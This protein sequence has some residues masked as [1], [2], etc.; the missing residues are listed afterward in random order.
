[1]IWLIHADLSPSQ[2]WNAS[3][4]AL[5]EAVGE[6]ATVVAP[7]F[8]YSFCQ[9]RPFDRLTSRGE[10]GL[11]GNYLLSRPDAIRSDHPI[12]SFAAIGPQAEELLTG[13]SPSAFGPGS[14]FERLH[15]KEGMLLFAGA[16]FQSCTYVHY[17]EQ[18]VGVSYRSSLWFSGFEYFARPLDGSVVTDLSRFEERLKRKGLLRPHRT[19]GLSISIQKLVEETQNALL[20]EPYFLLKQPP[21]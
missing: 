8:T 6:G 2:P 9:G 19:G 18:K 15:Q 5:I 11:F 16:S 21:K 7:T 13:L 12:F 20:E 14:L 17:V 3:A 10:S 1:M 4:E